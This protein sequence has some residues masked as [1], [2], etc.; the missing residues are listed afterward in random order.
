MKTRFLS[1]L[2]CITL[3]ANDSLRQEALKEGLQPVP[4][5]Y[6]ELLETLKTNRTYLSKEKIALGK[7]LFFDPSLSLNRD[8]SCASCHD[9]Q[10][11]GV[12][13]RPTAIG[14]KQQSNP[15]HLNTPTV[16]NTALST[17]LFWDGKATTLQEQAKGRPS[18]F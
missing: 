6:I 10:K 3:H 11:G 8:I 16:L 18:S 17:N 1:L 7:Q 9:F 4:K 2:L 12:D 15:H 14:H 13:G 5:S